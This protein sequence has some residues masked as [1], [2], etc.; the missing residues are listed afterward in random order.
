MSGLTKK[1]KLERFDAL[2][3]QHDLL[4]RYFWDSRDGY[5]PERTATYKTKDGDRYKASVYRTDLA[6]GGYIVVESK[7]GVPAI[8]WFEDWQRKV[9]D[10]AFSGE[11]SLAM[12][13]LAEQVRR[14]PQMGVQS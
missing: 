1:A 6:S 10:M 14:V 7:P 13:S 9:G 11:F 4:L 5:K 3:I 8:D 12:K 2:N